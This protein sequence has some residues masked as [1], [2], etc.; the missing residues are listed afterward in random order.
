MTSGREVT[1][2]PRSTTALWIIV[3]LGAAGLGLAGVR[4]A[5]AGTPDVWAWIGLAF[6]LLGLIVL[7]VATARVTAD[8]YG[9]RYRTFLRRWSVPWSDVADLGVRLRR[10]KSSDIY[11]VNVMLRD[12]RSRLLPLPSATTGD[13]AQFD[14]ELDALRAVH[15]RYGTPVSGHVPVVSHRTAG[16]GWIG[17][18]ALCALLLAGAA[19]S[20]SYVPDVASAERAWRAAAACT[21]ETPA[22]QRRECLS[23]M[24]AVVE[25]TDVGRGRKQSWLY[26]ADDRPLERISVTR[27]AAETFRSGD[28]V[29][30]TVWRGTVR[31]VAGERHVWR[32]HINT[33]T[34]MTV[35]AA[36]CALAAGYPGALVI[37]RVRWRRLPADEVL[38]SALPFAGALVGTALWLLPLCVLYPTTLF[39]DPVAVTWGAFGALV[40][41]LLFVWAWRAT[42]IRTPGMPREEKRQEKQKK[43]EEKEEVFLRARFL[44]HTD[45]NPYGFGTHVVLGGGP[46]SVAPHSGPGRFAVKPIPVERLTVRDIRRSRGDDGETVPRGWHVA[47]LDD[48][49]TPVRLAAAPADLTRIVRALGR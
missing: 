6:G 21:D 13:R 40:T 23:T 8:A 25:R 20:A 39:T 35:L 34:E 15:R 44:E 5:Y 36:L 45:Y 14:A 3:G 1:C 11:R 26:F 37:L 7:Y 33:P 32:E 10:G 42:R 22:A 28:R 24:P 46:P 38:P 29:E 2:R 16:R 27:E 4:V 19:T 12:G 41:V 17:S 47:E 30:L 49:G 43:Q 48:A 9:L 18:L 31:E